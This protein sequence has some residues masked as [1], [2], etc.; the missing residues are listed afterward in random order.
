MRSGIAS[1]ALYVLNEANGSHCL[2]MNSAKVRL[3]SGLLYHLSSFIHPSSGD[4]KWLSNNSPDVCKLAQVY[5][6]VAKTESF[7]LVALVE[8]ESELQQFNSSYPLDVLRF[9]K[10]ILEVKKALRA[11]N[12]RVLNKQVT[13]QNIVDLRVL[14]QSI[15]D[16]FEYLGLTNICISDE[17]LTSIQDQH[18]KIADD[19]E[20][21]LVRRISAKEW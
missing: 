15:T 21:M 10:F 17:R 1:S 5:K 4:L 7:R 9:C 20:S 12:R 11:W 14:A 6:L 8:D 2:D 18:Q 19:L 16:L 13:F 3:A